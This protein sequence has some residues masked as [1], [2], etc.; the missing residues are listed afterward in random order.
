MLQPKLAATAKEMRLLRTHLL[1]CLS[2]VGLVEAAPTAAADGLLAVAPML[3]ADGCGAWSAGVID[4]HATPA[5][6]ALAADACTSPTV[7]A[8][9]VAA[10]AAADGDHDEN[11]DF[12]VLMCSE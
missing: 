7:S 1:I 11:D 10:A 4:T 2:S 6:G 8:A 5:A 3:A 12:S 9:A